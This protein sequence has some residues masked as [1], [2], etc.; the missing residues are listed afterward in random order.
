MSKQ[1]SRT[2]ATACLSTAKPPDKLM[3]DCGTAV[4]TPNKAITHLRACN[5]WAATDAASWEDK[6]RA[7]ESAMGQFA[8][9]L[10]SC[11]DKNEIAADTAWATY[12][13]MCSLRTDISKRYQE[14]VSVA[15]NLD[16]SQIARALAPLM[17]ANLPDSLATA[18][19]PLIDKAVNNAF[20]KRAEAQTATD[21]AGA[22]PLTN[23]PNTDTV[24][25]R[26]DSLPAA[27]SAAVAASTQTRTY[28]QITANG[29]TQTSQRSWGQQDAIART[30]FK[31]RQLLINAKRDAPQTWLEEQ[32]QSLVKRCNIAIQ[33][34]VSQKGL[35][36]GVSDAKELEAGS[37]QK[38]P[39]GGAVF[40][41]PSKMAADWLQVPAHA[42]IICAAFDADVEV[43]RREYHIVIKNAPFDFPS[44][45]TPLDA[46]PHAPPP[47][48]LRML[49]IENKLPENSL[50]RETWI[51]PPERRSQHQRTAHALI[52]VSSPDIAN[53]LIDQK[54]C[55]A[56]YRFVTERLIPDPIRCA[57]CNL[58]GHKAAGCTSAMVC[59]KCSEVDHLARDCRKSPRCA[60]CTKAKEKN[61][62]HP[63]YDRDCPTLIYQREAR[64]ERRPEDS[65]PRFLTT[66]NISIAFPS[67]SQ[68]SIPIRQKPPPQGEAKRQAKARAAVATGA[69]AVHKQPS[70]T[71]VSRASASSPA[72]SC[73]TS[74]APPRSRGRTTRNSTTARSQTGS[75]V[76]SPAPALPHT[77]PPSDPAQ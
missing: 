52:A 42:A 37:M 47:H 73:E 45:P 62:D 46:D 70:K 43:K 6:F 31:E 17:A 3:T 41:L 44:F 35:P 53:Q 51:R 75:R 50:I 29:P 54:L 22:Y 24:L 19:S 39:S 64:R 60:A 67:S 7:L 25:A 20:D 66:G 38:L 28:S 48:P 74:P 23:A 49:E 18:L 34:V 11:P 59:S 63:C 33:E 71:P 61:N 55:W 14:M 21:W 56:G 32:P 40:D 5:I 69:N 12:L 13:T 1:K 65:L 27:V 8:G 77:A 26:L 72:P 58:Y 4:S 2:S 57:K 30:G 36:E 9:W 68:H 16:A 10:S 76:V 15:Q